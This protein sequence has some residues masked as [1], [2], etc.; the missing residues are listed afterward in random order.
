MKALFASE[1]QE[2]RK[3]LD[4]LSKKNAQFQIDTISLKDENEVKAKR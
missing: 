3:L 2:T 4:E 1:L